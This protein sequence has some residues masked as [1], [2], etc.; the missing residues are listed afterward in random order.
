[1]PGHGPPASAASTAKAA[2]RSGRWRPGSAKREREGGRSIFISEDI[3]RRPGRAGLP[4]PAMTVFGSQG[5]VCRVDEDYAAPAV[6]VAL[7]A[8]SET[9]GSESTLH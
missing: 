1:M 9:P 6:A 8:S 7:T 3:R 5:R 2:G 4:A